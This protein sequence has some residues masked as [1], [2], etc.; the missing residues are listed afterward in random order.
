MK[1]FGTQPW[2][3]QKLHNYVYLPDLVRLDMRTQ[4]P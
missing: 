2:L 1:H 4:L 3:T